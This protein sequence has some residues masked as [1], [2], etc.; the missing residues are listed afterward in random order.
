MAETA[1]RV[2]AG[3][4]V[5]LTLTPEAV[6]GTFSAKAIDAAGRRMR[7]STE[8]SGSNVI[9]T[10][11]ESEWRDGRPG[12]G[13]VELKRAYDGETTYPVCQQLRILPG[14]DACGESTDDY[15]W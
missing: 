5:T 3:Q 7:A 6:T 8:V 1:T 12:I 2:R 13:R 10:I 4:T 14:I 11:N 15:P 9:V